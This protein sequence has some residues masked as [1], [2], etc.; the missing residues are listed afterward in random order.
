LSLSLLATVFI[1]RS[2]HVLCCSAHV[3]CTDLLVR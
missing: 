1:V 3:D 2:A